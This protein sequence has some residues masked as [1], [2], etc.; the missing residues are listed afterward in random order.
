MMNFREV[1]FK[2]LY[3]VLC[4]TVRRSFVVYLH[5]QITSVRE[6][7][8]FCKTR[9]QKECFVNSSHDYSL[10]QLSRLNEEMNSILIT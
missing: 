3:M 5:F 2:I 1:G 9:K 10:L 4:F 7:I 6:L 8:M